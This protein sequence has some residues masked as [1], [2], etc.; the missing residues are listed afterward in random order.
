ML[1]VLLTEFQLGLGL[2]HTRT[3]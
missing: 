1:P 3:S 2:L